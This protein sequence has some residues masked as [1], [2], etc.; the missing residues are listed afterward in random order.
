MEKASWLRLLAAFA[1]AG[2]GLAAAL[3]LRAPPAA[4][5]IAL[6]AGLAALAVVLLPRAEPELHPES[7]S[8]APDSP[9]PGM[10]DLIR[11]LEEPMLLVR[12]RRVVAANE[13]ARTLLGRHIEGTD[14]R[15]A[16]RHPAA[17]ERLAGPAAEGD[18]ATTRTELVGLGGAD[19]H[20]AMTA[21]RLPDG[22]RLVHLADLSQ[23]RA[24]EQMRADFVAN[25]SHELRTP[26]ATLLGFLETLQDEAAAGDAATRTRFLKIMF[27]EATRM[28]TLVDDLMSLSRIEAERFAAPADPVDLAPVIDSV[29]RGLASLSE[30]RGRRSSSRTRPSRRSSPATAAS[31]PNCSATSSPTRSITA[32]PARRCGSGSRRPAAG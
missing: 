7:P 25:A 31:S 21:T 20:W 18:Q 15:L 8:D 5:L 26:L 12:E 2:A 22:S 14:V 23:A 28:R 24:A 1:L 13:A 30:S 11:A 9:L 3:L 32:G 27:D 6:F 17:A 29:R 10:A 16:I 19:R 4:A